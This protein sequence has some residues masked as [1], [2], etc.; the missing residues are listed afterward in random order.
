MCLD[1]RTDASTDDT[2][3]LLQNSEGEEIKKFILVTSR[4]KVARRKVRCG[5]NQGDGEMQMTE[6]IMEQTTIT[7]KER[8]KEIGEESGKERGK[9]KN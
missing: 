6:A 5:N 3:S 9:E 7:N 2:D 1:Q 4:R 8:G